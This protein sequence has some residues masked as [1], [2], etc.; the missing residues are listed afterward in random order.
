MFK[1]LRNVFFAILLIASAALVLWQA[2]FEFT[3][4]PSNPGQTYFFF[5]VSLLIFLLMVTLGFRLA[6]IIVKAWVDGR[7]DRYGSRIRTKLV[8]GALALS[9]LPV[10]FMVLF[11]MEVM[12]RSLARW[13]YRPTEHLMDDYKGVLNAVREQTRGKA[14]A[15]A[16]LIASMPEAA[17]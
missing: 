10:L 12:N 16:Q 13:F 11:N 14:L 9:L 6:R 2:Q 17:A 4:S 5:A 8:F 7:S 15:E 3:F 1:P